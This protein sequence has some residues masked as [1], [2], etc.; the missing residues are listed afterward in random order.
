MK[1]LDELYRETTRKVYGASPTGGHPVVI[2]EHPY[3]VKLP[4]VTISLGARA[5]HAIVDGILI[6]LLV[7]GFFLAIQYLT[8]AGLPSLTFVA[9]FPAFGLV[10]LYYALF[11]SVFQQTPGK[12][13]TG[14]IV[15]DEYGQ[16]ITFST[17]ALRTVLRLVPF[18]GFSF[19]FSVRGWHDSWSHTYVMSRQQLQNRLQALQSEEESTY[20]ALIV[21]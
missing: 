8:P 17:A 21:E 16:K 18:D 7:G 6:R 19:L 14:A 1:K 15:V 5:I 20:D 12:M 4:V 13:L 9:L 10:F 2:E 11:E 3:R